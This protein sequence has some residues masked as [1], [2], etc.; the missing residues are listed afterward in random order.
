MFVL[1]HERSLETFRRKRL[2]TQR[3][4]MKSTASGRGAVI[5]AAALAIFI[6]TSVVIVRLAAVCLA[7][8]PGSA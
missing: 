8:T 7:R 5:K 6:I 2:Q 3:D 4:P 1:A